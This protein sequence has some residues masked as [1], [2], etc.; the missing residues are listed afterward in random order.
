MFD[1]VTIVPIVSVVRLRWTVFAEA[2][3]IPGRD[4]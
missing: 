2:K 3:R 4:K 1:E